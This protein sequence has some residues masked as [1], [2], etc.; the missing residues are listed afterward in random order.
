MDVL[1][2]WLW[3]YSISAGLVGTEKAAP[4]RPAERLGREDISVGPEVKIGKGAVLEGGVSVGAFTSLGAGSRASR[5][6]VGQNCVI[7]AGAILD[8]CYLHDGVQVGDGARLERCLVCDSVQVGAGARVGEGCVLGADVVVAP[9]HSVPPFSRVTCR[10]TVGDGDDYDDDDEVVG[11]GGHGW[12]WDRPG[13]PEGAGSAEGDSPRRNR[14]S[15]VES[16]DDGPS[17]RELFLLKS[18]V[19][20]AENCGPVYD[21]PHAAARAGGGA[22]GAAV[23]ARGGAGGG[24]RAGGGG[25]TNR[26]KTRS[27]PRCCS[28][29]RCR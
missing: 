10:H 2:Q 21:S 15:G 25:T 18:L 23:G 28:P 20:R 7:G 3:P 16:D 13:D 29:G 22:G 27:T 17:D 4:A 24:A 12:L 5:R 9:H 19:P 11:A 26:R 14:H 6:V 1:G 8:G